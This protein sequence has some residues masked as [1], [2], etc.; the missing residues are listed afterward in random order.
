M[1]D[2]V[3]EL[4]NAGQL[5]DAV[6]KSNELVANNPRDM[7]S[8][9][10]LMQLVCFNGDWERV[11]KISGQLKALDSEG[12]HM[13]LI[14]FVDQQVTA[15]TIRDQ[16]W[17]QGMVPDFVREPDELSQKILWAWNCRRMG[18]VAKY[19][20]AIDWVL[21]NT[22]NITAE[23]NGEKHEGFRDF[24]DMSS[25]VLEAFTINGLYLWVPLPIVRQIVVAKP[26]RPVDF[27]WAK[28]KLLLDDDT[29][30]A[31][32]LPSN[33]FQSSES[34]S[35]SVRLGRETQWNEDSHGLEKGLGRRLFLA[36]D[37]EFTYFDFEKVILEVAK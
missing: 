2:Q 29:E 14:N 26:I 24:D 37:D 8:R 21:D 33:Y 36:G 22:P 3:I 11:R 30:L 28:S 4:F 5:D 17:T 1:I 12:E 6:A 35:Q 9:L 34:E 16:T 7:A 27:L 20:E 19:T 32:Y 13:A 15:E 25:C 10:V 23:I 18:E 31:L